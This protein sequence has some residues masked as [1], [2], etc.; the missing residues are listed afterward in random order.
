MKPK[1]FADIAMIFQQADANGD[2]LLSKDEVLAHI[3]ESLS[4]NL[5][6]QF[7]SHFDQASKQLADDLFDKYFSSLYAKKGTK[8]V[9]R[10]VFVD[11]V[12]QELKDDWHMRDLIIQNV[13]HFDTD[14][15][16]MLSDEEIKLGLGRYFQ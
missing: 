10:Q 1:D 8:E 14:K 2:D 4:K 7:F 11:F 9:S 6:T 13:D 5:F 12:S 3:R 16:G 15:N